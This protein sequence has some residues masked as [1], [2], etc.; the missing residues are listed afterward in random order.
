M[1]PIGGIS[2]HTW[3][4]GLRRLSSLKSPVKLVTAALTLFML[5]AATAF[6]QTSEAGGEATLQLPDL[7]S[8][9]FLGMTGHNLLLIGLLF[10]GFGLLFGLAIYIQLKNLPVHRSMR[11]VPSSSSKPARRTWLRRA[12]S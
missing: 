8:V 12:S 7:S 5:N 3:L 1:H 10:C 11:G 9:S 2:T 6:A 4:A